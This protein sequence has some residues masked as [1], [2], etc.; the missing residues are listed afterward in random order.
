MRLCRVWLSVCL[1]AV[2]LGQCQ[3]ETAEKKRLLP[4]TALLGRVLSRAARPNPLQVCGTAR[5]PHVE[6][7]LR[8]EPRLGQL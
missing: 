2:V 8:C 4:S 1:C 6:L 7:P 5:G 3:R